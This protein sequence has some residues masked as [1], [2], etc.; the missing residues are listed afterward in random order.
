MAFFKLFTVSKAKLCNLYMALAD[1]PLF[2][3]KRK[4]I[5]S[6]ALDTF[7]ISININCLVFHFSATLLI[8]LHIYNVLITVCFEPCQNVHAHTPP[9]QKPFLTQEWNNISKYHFCTEQEQTI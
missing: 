3:T 1:L 7:D 9:A 6:A 8:C 2:L 5:L 4:I